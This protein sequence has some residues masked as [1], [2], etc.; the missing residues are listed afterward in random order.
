MT[1]NTVKRIYTRHYPN[2]DSLKA[3]VEW[4]DATLYHG[5][6]VPVSSHMG[7]LFD[8]GLREGLTVGHETW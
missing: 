2:N 1:H 5:V 7:A 8:R 3:Y 6:R 4:G